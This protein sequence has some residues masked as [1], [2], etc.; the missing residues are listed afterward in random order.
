MKRVLILCAL[1]AACATAGAPEP[2]VFE[3]QAIITEPVFDAQELYFRYEPARHHLLLRG[4]KVGAKDATAGLAETFKRA[5][6]NR[7]F[8]KDNFGFQR[9]T[10]VQERAYRR[11]G[12]G[13][14]VVIF[15]CELGTSET[16]L[17]VTLGDF[18]SHAVRRRMAV[19]VGDKELGVNYEGEPL[20]LAE[21]NSLGHHFMRKGD[22]IERSAI[23]WSTG[24]ALYEA[25]FRRP[26]N[27]HVHTFER[28]FGSGQIESPP[29]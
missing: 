17:S 5:I 3:A 21:N 10:S 14:D 27:Q 8:C 26:G 9:W 28:A 11:E 2:P 1:A 13:G 12:K 16:D 29:R 7:T 6:A 20:A 25:V 22:V 19:A 23:F 18:F 15:E 24:L 4:Y